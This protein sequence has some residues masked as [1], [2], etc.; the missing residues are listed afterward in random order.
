MKLWPLLAKKLIVLPGVVGEEGWR[1]LKDSGFFRPVRGTGGLCFCGFIPPFF[2]L[3]SSD[4]V[5][6]NWDPVRVGIL[7]S[8]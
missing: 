4:T 8:F 2:F 1:R 7:V 5:C 6:S 3:N